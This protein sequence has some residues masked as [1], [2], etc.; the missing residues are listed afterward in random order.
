[1]YIHICIYI[2]VY[3]CICVCVHIY[4]HTHI[5]THIHTYVRT[6][7][8]THTHSRTHAHTHTHTHTFIT[9]S[10]ASSISALALLMAHKSPSSLPVTNTDAICGCARTKV[11]SS[12]NQFR[13]YSRNYSSHRKLLFTYMRM[14]AH[15]GHVISVC[16]CI[17]PIRLACAEVPCPQNRCHAPR[18]GGGVYTHARTP[19]FLAAGVEGVDVGLG[20]PN[21]PKPE[22]RRVSKESY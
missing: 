14:R 21:V 12:V 17:G 16:I 8:H 11:T 20:G 19:Y 15:T 1:M 22:G 6:C 2:Y 10:I 13:D 7:I 3:I 5:T 4:T 18:H 9:D